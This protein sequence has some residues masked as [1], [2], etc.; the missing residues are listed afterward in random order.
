MCRH[1]TWLDLSLVDADHR[2]I[3]VTLAPEYKTWVHQLV[4]GEG[5]QEEEEISLAQERISS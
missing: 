1:Q 3:S 4:H 2:R 5:Y